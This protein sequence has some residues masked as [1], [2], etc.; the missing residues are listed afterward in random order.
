MVDEE[1]AEPDRI[2]RAGLPFS[3]GAPVADG[4]VLPQ[5]LVRGAAVRLLV[6]AHDPPALPDPYTGEGSM[7]PALRRRCES[8]RE[9]VR[10]VLGKDR[11]RHGRRKR[12]ADRTKHPVQGVQDEVGVVEHLSA[13]RH[14]H[15]PAG[16]GDEE[17]A[18]AGL[19][20]EGDEM[21]EHV[22]SPGRTRGYTPS[23][24]G[25]TALRPPAAPSRDR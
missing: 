12:A 2:G 11:E 1:R 19:G 5:E 15:A 20:A 21:F 22:A 13:M 10:D 6:M 23:R 3:G 17:V 9:R 25:G 24:Q 8:L 18:P 14:G 7:V 16:K 4:K